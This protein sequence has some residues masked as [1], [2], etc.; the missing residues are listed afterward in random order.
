MRGG[1]AETHNFLQ[2]PK[3][4]RTKY[5]VDRWLIVYLETQ[6]LPGMREALWKVTLV[7]LKKYA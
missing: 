4:Y 2:E 5:V 1:S 6:G 7:N 3:L